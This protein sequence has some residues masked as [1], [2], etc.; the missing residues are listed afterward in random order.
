MPKPKTIR[1]SQK[2]NWK[3]WKLDTGTAKQERIRPKYSATV[4]SA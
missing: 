3:T 4:A 1:K 2:I